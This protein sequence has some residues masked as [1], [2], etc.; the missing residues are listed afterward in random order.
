MLKRYKLVSF[1][2]VAIFFLVS[3][4]NSYISDIKPKKTVGHVTESSFLTDEITVAPES[5]PVENIVVEETVP[6]LMLIGNTFKIKAKAQPDEATDQGLIYSVDNGN[7]HIAEDGTVRALKNGSATITIASKSN[8]GI[9]KRVTVTIKKRPEIALNKTEFEIES[10]EANPAFTVKTLH[11]KLNYKPEIIGGGA[12]WL[13]FDKKV[14][15][16]ESTDTIT[17]ICQKNK[18]VWER[19]AYIKFKDDNNKYIKEPGTNKDMEV[20]LTQK[21]NE[22]PVVT[23]KWVHGIDAPL[24][25]EK[26]KIEI[27]HTYPTEYWDNSYIFFWNES[28]TTKWFNNRKVN[29]LGINT[30]DGGDTNQCWAK[31]AA[32]M[33]DWWFE[34]NKTNIARYIEKEPVTG[35]DAEKYMYF[36][37]REFQDEQEKEKSYIANIFRTQ[38]H[39]GGQGDYAMSGLMWYLYGNNSVSSPKIKAEDPSFIG[40]ALFKDVFDKDHTPI[41]TAIGHTKKEFEDALKN[42]LDS[43]KAIGINIKGTKGSRLAYGH[44]ITLWGAAFDEDGNILAVYVVDNNNKENRIFPY[45]IHYKNDIYTGTG[46]NRPYLFNFPNNAADNDKYIEEITTLDTGEAQW[47][48][49]LKAH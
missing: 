33:L 22:H 32:N 25:A 27:P 1:A 16:D 31:T 37:K 29:N 28:E 18:T 7:V 15:T 36:Y 48:K 9:T 30:P 34:Q 6:K 19:S 2:A 13:S 40:P 11:G 23:I 45:G 14:S 12:K 49:W 3:C 41:A 42:A 46:E 5:V 44:W 20:K 24:P 39:N 26:E 10:T 38:A 8:S 43:K 17:L 47:E 35:A 21:K 4:K